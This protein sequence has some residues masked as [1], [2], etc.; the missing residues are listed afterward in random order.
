MLYIYIY[1]QCILVHVDATRVLLLDESHAQSLS[2]SVTEL[3]RDLSQ[4]DAAKTFPVS[5][6]MIMVTACY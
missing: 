4:A 2:S 6:I 5:I 1:I 3:L